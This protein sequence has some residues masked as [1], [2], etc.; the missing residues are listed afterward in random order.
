MHLLAKTA[1]PALESPTI[2]RTV[3]HEYSKNEG[4]GASFFFSRGGGDAGHAG[5]FVTTVAVQLAN[6]VLSLKHYICEAIAD[7]GDITSKSLR[8]QWDYYAPGVTTALRGASYY[9]LI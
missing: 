9:P 5:K 8:D 3:A 4:L 2:A 7:R 6:N 1:W